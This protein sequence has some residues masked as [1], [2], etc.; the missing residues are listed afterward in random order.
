MADGVT[1]KITGLEQLSQKMQEF[2]EKMLKKGVRT[3]L[4][5]GGEVLRQAISDAA[6]VS[7]DETHVHPPGFLKDHIGSKVTVSVKNDTGTI[8]VGPVKKA[9]YAMF[10]EFGTKH[11]PAKPFIRPAF[12]GNAQKALDAFVNKLREA[13]KEALA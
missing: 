6:P 9:F 11:Q 2:P 13:F 3:A 7:E 12:E 5:A 4:R 8:L 1:V 10:P